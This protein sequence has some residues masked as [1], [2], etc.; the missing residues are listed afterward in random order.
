MLS[1]YASQAFCCHRRTLA[2]QVDSPAGVRVGAWST[3]STVVA[4]LR[5][6][7][8]HFNRMRAAPD[9][10][11]GREIELAHVGEAATTA[12]STVATASLVG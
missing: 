10:R 5:A 6:E 7:A 4:T 1:C 3:I 11:T 8:P 2:L 12:G 9:C